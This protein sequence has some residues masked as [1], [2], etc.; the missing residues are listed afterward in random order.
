MKA[1]EDEYYRNSS[2]LSLLSLLKLQ[3]WYALGKLRA[4]KA[5]WRVA[6]ERGL[7][8]A[9]ICPGLLK[10]SEFFIRNTTSTIAYLKGKFI[11]VINL[12]P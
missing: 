9:T 12:F 3:L 2:H 4:E 1:P 5:A 10:G 11:F 6:E 8:L 7:K